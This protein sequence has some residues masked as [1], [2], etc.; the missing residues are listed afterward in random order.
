MR[1][2]SIPED[3]SAFVVSWLLGGGLGVAALVLGNTSGLA[4][5]AAWFAVLM[6]GLLLFTVTISKQQLD[7]RAIGTGDKIPTFSAHDEF[8][9]LF[10]SRELVGQ[11]VL[12]KF[13]RG[14]W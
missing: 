12:I 1:R 13:F 5:A 4:T 11:F 2:V 6:A 7:D 9:K 8:G 10:D 14:H 3:R